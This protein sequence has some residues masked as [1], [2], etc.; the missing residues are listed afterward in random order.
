MTAN[1]VIAAAFFAIA[2]W[3]FY[4]PNVGKWLA[5]K[6]LI[7]RRELSDHEARKMSSLARGAASV[8]AVSIILDKLLDLSIKVPVMILAGLVVFVLSYQLSMHFLCRGQVKV[9]G[10][11]DQDSI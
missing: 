7:G 8:I 2:G 11:I 10:A 3:L 4:T 9:E 6:Q 5:S 1:D